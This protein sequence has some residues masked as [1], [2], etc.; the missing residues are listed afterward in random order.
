[1]FAQEAAMLRRPLVVVLLAL[2]GCSASSSPNS[3]GSCAGGHCDAA[4]QAQALKSL[5]L[6]GA[7][8]DGST[9]R[10]K[11]CH[12]LTRAN[13]RNWLSMSQSFKSTCLASGMA[14]LDSVNCVRA[15]PADATSPYVANKLGIYA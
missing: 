9:L 14:A 7:N 3:G 4:D 15:N 1:P 11:E 12:S 13:L 10:C 2:A 6:L 8:V 5:Q